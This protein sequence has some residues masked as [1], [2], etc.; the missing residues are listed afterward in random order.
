MAAP[1]GTPT[2]A[3]GRPP[4]DATSAAS[5]TG[6]PA[7]T[8]TGGPVIGGGTATTGAGTDINS[9]VGRAVLN[10][11]VNR[12]RIPFTVDPFSQAGEV[13]GTDLLNARTQ[14]VANLYLGMDQVHASLKQLVTTLGTPVAPAQ[15]VGSLVQPDGTAAG[16]LQIQFDPSTLGSTSPRVTVQ[17]GADGSFQLSLPPNMP[18]PAGSNVRLDI[19]GS[20]SNATVQIPAAQIAGNGLVGAL[21]LPNFV[22]PLS[23]SILAALEALTAPPPNT[24]PPPAPTNQPQL[25]VV[26]IGDDADCLLSYGLNTSIDRFPYGV[27]FRLIEPRASIVS[28]VRV[29]GIGDR[30]TF[31]PSYASSFGVSATKP[32]QPGA[33]PDVPPANPGEGQVTYVDRVPVEQP[34][35]VDGFRDQMMGL[36]ANGLFTGDETRPMAGTLGLGYVLSMSQHWTFQGLALGNLVYSLPLAPG[37]QQQVAIFE[38]T[39]TSSVF[40]SEFLSEEQT[41]FQRATAD[42]STNATFNSAFNEAVHGSSSFRTDSTSSSW[43]GSLI[44]VSGGSGSSSSSGSSQQSL[45]G[46]RN[47]SQQAAQSTHSAAENQAAARRTA[48]RTGMRVATASESQQVTTKTIANHNH[49]RALTMQYWEVLRLYDVTAAIDGLTLCVLVPLQVVRFMPPNQPAILSTPSQVGSRAQ[50]LSRYASIIKHGDVLEQALP[51]RYRHGL[52]MLLQFA[53]D[54]TAQ[55]EPFGSV[56]EDVVQFN[57]RGTF[58]PSEDIYVTIVTDRGTRVGPVKLANTAPFI[59]ADAFTTKEQLLGWLTALRQSAAGVVF[60]GALAIPPSLNRTSVVGFEISRGFRQISYTLLSPAVAELNALQGI[61]G[62]ATTWVNQALQSTLSPGATARTTV[63]L[64]PADQESNLGGPLLYAFQAAINEVDGS[65]N[66]LPSPQEQYANDTL[67]GIELPPQTY[68][69]P[70]RQL[71]PV[72]R[73]KEVL[74]IEKM[75][76]HVVRGTLTYSHAIWASMSSDERAILLEAY[77]IGV[78][79][80]GVPDASQMVPLLNCVENRVLGYFGNSMILP[81]IIPDVLAKQGL[82]D[83]RAAAG[84]LDPGKIQDALLAFHQFAFKPPRS[85]IALPTRGVLGEAV[86][87]HCASAEKLDITRFW[88]WQDSPGDTAPQI[89]P[90]TLPTTTPSLTAGLTAPNSLTTLPSLINNVLTAPSPDTS[91]LQALS[92]AAASQ[93]DFSSSLTGADQLANLLTNAQNNANSAR[94]DALKTTKDLTAQ[95]IA[96]VGN[97]VGGMKGN[98]T[99]GSTAAAAVSGKSDGTTPS[100]SGQGSGQGTG[101]KTGTGGTGTGGTGGTGGGG[102]G[103]TGGGGTGGGGTGGGGTGGGGTGGGGTGGGGTGGGGTGGPTPAPGPPA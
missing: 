61:F 54:P 19:H 30:F 56:A 35:S 26:K 89:S 40:E 31:L 41:E 39:D 6:A 25:P 97:I 75:A 80:G 69:V 91:L 99:A 86:L 94:A 64:T 15:L 72:L 27:F 22:A 33:L 66:T 3:P 52:S 12:Q 60:T 20:T 17:S 84:A 76:Q 78:P 71:S 96:T 28:Q 57:L 8:A 36:Q 101:G 46:Q 24:A 65:G 73:Y 42:T 90:V 51:R 2:P 13:L 70:A 67:A 100:G 82:G 68:P 7:G 55:V 4:A 59:P 18:L 45:E 93:Q 11:E 79:P 50:V 14:A 88:N 85:T 63:Y 92:K 10:I 95:T 16:P 74:E 1:I 49:T 53:A 37:E 43:G 48:S 34:I 102:T 87:G 81:F 29:H 9:D 98:P 77:T 47:T 21:K 32:V 103:G 5:N 83:G 23:P 44:F 58:L 62:G 38:R